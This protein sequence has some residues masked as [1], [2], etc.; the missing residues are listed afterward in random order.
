[1]T[2]ARF[3]AAVRRVRE[4]LAATS[5]IARVALADQLPLMWNGHHVIEMDEGGEGPDRRASSSTAHRVSTAA[6]EPD[7]FAT[8]DAAANRGPPAGA[9]RLRGRRAGRGRQRVVRQETYSAA[10][11]PSAVA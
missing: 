10:A 2:Q 5:G 3:E 8:F 9:G 1:M 4:D 7:F 11:M 6:V